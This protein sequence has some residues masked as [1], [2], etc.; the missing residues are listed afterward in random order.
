MCC[1]AFRGMVDETARHATHTKGEGYRR[2]QSAKLVV[3]A[4]ARQ[5]VVAGG[6]ASGG[7]GST[8][9]KESE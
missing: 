4:A 8:E 9:Q 6:A 2:T 5:G 3:G 1:A 7:G